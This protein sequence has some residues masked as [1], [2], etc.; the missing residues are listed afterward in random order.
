MIDLQAAGT[1]LRCRLQLHAHASNGGQIVLTPGTIALTRVDVIVT[2]SGKVVGGTLRL[3]PGSSLSGDAT[4]QANV[5]SAGTT[6]P[7]D[8][9]I[10]CSDD[11]RAISRSMVPVLSMS[12]S[13]A[14]RPGSHTISLPSP[15]PCSL[16]ARSR[17]SQR[18]A[19]LPQ[20]GNQF[21]IITYA[22]RSG[23]FSTYNGLNYATGKTFQTVYS[24]TNFTLVAATA[25]IRVFPTTGLAHQQGRRLRRASRSC[26][27]PSPP[28]NVTLNLQ[29]EQHVRGDRLPEHPDVHDGQL[30]RTADR[31]GDWRRR[32]SIGQRAVSGRLRAGGEHGHE[33]QRAD[34]DGVSLTNLPDEVENIQVANL[35]VTPSTGLNQGSSLTV[36]WND[37]NTGNLPA[38]ARGTTRS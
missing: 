30:E 9:G 25:D 21:S 33:L 12:R 6:N 18:M 11:R 29:L 10:G 17:S 24:A 13:A 27:P 15:V 14:R 28:P 23:E 7:G 35:A 26:S 5:I 36:T 37:S 4:I 20:V 8:N 3:F 22:S 1:S 34:A 19:S 38:A 31:H 2:S 16:A 32:P